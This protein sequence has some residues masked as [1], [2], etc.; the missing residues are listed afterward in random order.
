[1]NNTFCPAC[2]TKVEGND[3]KFCTSCGYNFNGQNQMNNQNAGNANST[4]MNNNYDINNN[5]TTYNGVKAATNGMGVTG[6]VISLI[7][8]IFC[9]GSLSW[10]GLIF[11]IIGLNKSK[12]TGIGKGL[13]IA[14]LVINIIGL[15]YL[16]FWGVIFL[17][18]FIATMS[19]VAMI[20]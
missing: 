2:G 12:T 16:I 5:F 18:P 11:S 8:L 3:T 14:G 9:C 17:I 19:E 7:S 15:L 1:M 20:I 4:G 13:S 10:L 6:F